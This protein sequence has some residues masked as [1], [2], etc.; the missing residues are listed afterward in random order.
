MIVHHPY[1]N[2]QVL[3]TNKHNVHDNNGGYKICGHEINILL[4]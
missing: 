2:T 4:N 1:I 3:K